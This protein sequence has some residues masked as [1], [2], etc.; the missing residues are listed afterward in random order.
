M[1]HGQRRDDIAILC[2]LYRQGCCQRPPANTL[3][4]FLRHRLNNGEWALKHVNWKSFLF[5]NNFLKDGLK[6]IVAKVQL[7]Y[8]SWSLLK[9]Y[10]VCQLLHIVK[11]AFQN[12]QLLIDGS[13]G[14]TV[15]CPQAT[16]DPSFSSIAQQRWRMGR[17]N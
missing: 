11:F 17:T 2:R 9:I 13:G 16:Q 7:T 10:S 1:L 12:L 8:V 14:L 3:V 4:L 5:K 6:N 15:A